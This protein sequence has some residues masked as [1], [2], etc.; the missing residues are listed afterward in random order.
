MAE[1]RERPSGMAAFSI[2][3]AGQ[4]L[5][6]LGTAITQFGLTL[7]VYEKTGKATPLALIGFFFVVPMVILGPFVGALIDRSNRKLMM[8]L[9]DLAAAATTSIIL[10]LYISGLLQIWHLRYFSGVSVARILRSDL[11][12]DP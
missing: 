1:I 2:I 12:H 8:M 7:W 4:I 11:A 6:L 10:V 9:S 3:W 5:S